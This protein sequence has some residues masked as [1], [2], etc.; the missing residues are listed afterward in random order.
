MNQVC[1]E[2]K[3][4]AIS[5]KTLIKFQYALPTLATSEFRM[6]PMEKEIMKT[7]GAFGSMHDYCLMFFYMIPVKIGQLSCLTQMK[8]NKCLHN[9]SFKEPKF[10]FL[11]GL[12]SLI[13]IWK[14]QPVLF[15]S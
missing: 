13:K 2:E 9:S 14:K 3:G 6:K 12:L 5:S 4:L 8:C 15:T 7:D 1:E 11:L 10:N